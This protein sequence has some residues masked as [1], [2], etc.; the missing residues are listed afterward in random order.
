MITNVTSHFF[1]VSVSP[2]HGL[3]ATASSSPIMSPSRG[4]PTTGDATI[5]SPARILAPLSSDSHVTDRMGAMGM[6]RLH[7]ASRASSSCDDSE[8]S[9]ADMA[10]VS[11]L[12]R[13]L[14]QVYRALVQ[15]M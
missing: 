7:P 11:V 4:V 12:D 8:L 15:G 3:G 10:E 9:D 13:A 1:C 14:P 2:D 6:E 5:T